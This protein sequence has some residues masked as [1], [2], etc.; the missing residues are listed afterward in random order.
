M[1]AV[2]RVTSKGRITVPSAVRVALGISAGDHLL[3]RVEG[4]R[5]VLVR[6]PDFPS[7][8][9]TLQVPV[10]KRNAT[11]SEVIRETRSARVTTRHCAPCAT[12][13]TELPSRPRHRLSA[14]HLAAMPEGNHHD[15]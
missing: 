6:S 13:S 9:G 7:L 11:W 2:A 15:Q 4:D 8:A 12:D 3:F 1:D 14:V 10:A 5:A